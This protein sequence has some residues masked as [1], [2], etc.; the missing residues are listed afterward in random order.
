[1]NKLKQAV[2]LYTGSLFRW[3]LPKFGLNATSAPGLIARRIYPN[4][5]QTLLN[6]LSEAPV[7]VTGTN[8]KSTT[9]GLIA[10]I[11]ESAAID[12]LH[13]VSGANLLTGLVTLLLGE[14]ERQKKQLL[15]ETDEAVLHYIT[16]HRPAQIVLV[17]NFF[18]DQLDRF[19]E[20]DSTVKLVQS[21]INLSSDGCL[22]ANVDDP[23]N[24]LLQAD[25]ILYYGLKGVEQRDNTMLA[26]ELSVCPSCKGELSY[27]NQWLGQL[28]DFYCDQCHYQK[29][30]PHIYADNIILGS[31]GSQFRVHYPDRQAIDIHLPLIGLFNVYNAVAA[32]A[33][34]YTYGI[35]PD[36]IKQGV[37]KYQ[38]LFGR[39]Q[40]IQ[41]KNKQI[42]L[43]LIKNPIG[44]TEV[45]RLIGG[46]SKKQIMIAI[47]DKYADGRDISWLWDIDC[48]HLSDTA[49][50]MTTGSR[51]SDMAIRLKYAGC[52]GIRYE[53]DLQDALDKVILSAEGEE[54]IY[55]LC[56]YT[57]LLELTQ[58]LNLKY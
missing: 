33:A 47:N 32:I 10:S 36:S 51:G 8:G 2:S 39:S 23:Y 19:G 27:I 17:T 50:I 31:E 25:N 40:K 13:N 4:I 44:G 43:F 34:S 7:L 30:Q 11:F 5:Y 35:D 52:S 38:P 58:I 29:P 56:T 28:G 45:V 53:L 49:G 14:Q 57:A 6:D 54:P 24:C 16:T 37:E 41:Y 1:M 46:E 12:H 20:L 3:I 18:R 22:V 15:F 21:G 55:I 42:Y 9:A 26:S 48:D